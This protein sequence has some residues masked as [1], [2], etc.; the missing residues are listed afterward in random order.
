[1][2][3]CWTVYSHIP[4]PANSQYLGEPGMVVLYVRGE[5]TESLKVMCPLVM[6]LIVC[7]QN[8][9]LDVLSSR[10]SEYDLI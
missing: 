6:G 8:S 9:Y 1:M 7:P 4:Y 3:Y 2:L 10:T 5:E